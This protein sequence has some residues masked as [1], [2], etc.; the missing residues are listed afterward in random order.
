MT[1]GKGRGRH[2]KAISARCLANGECYGRTIGWL[3]GM[4]AGDRQ[5]V[6]EATALCD[7]G[8]QVRFGSQWFRADPDDP[9]AAVAV[10]ATICKHRVAFFGPIDA[11]FPPEV[12]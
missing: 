12:A 8:A 7:E 11:V 3:A 1:A 5:L 4:F 10:I 6:A 2:T 9:K